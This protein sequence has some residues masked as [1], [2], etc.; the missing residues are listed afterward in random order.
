[1]VVVVDSTGRGMVV[2]VCSVVVVVDTGA[3]LLHPASMVALANKATP[4]TL[5]KRVDTSII[6]WLLNE[7]IRLQPP[8]SR[9]IRPNE[10]GKTRSRVLPDIT[11]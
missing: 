2:V 3:G 1:M 7:Q 6:V 5:G 9:G 8:G 10:S 11:T 4:R